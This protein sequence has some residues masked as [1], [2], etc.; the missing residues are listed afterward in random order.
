M[1]VPM[2]NSTDRLVLVP[3]TQLDDL[4]ELARLAV[5]RLPETDPLRS[6]LLGSVAGV[7]SAALSE[8]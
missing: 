8:P 4:L 1:L 3:A 5:D 6:C 2:M 7:R